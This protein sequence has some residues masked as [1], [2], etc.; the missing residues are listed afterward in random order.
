[1]QLKVQNRSSFAFKQ[2]ESILENDKVDKDTAS[3]LAGVPTNIITNG[4]GQYLAFLL[5]K[6]PQRKPLEKDDD[7]KKRLAK[8]KHVIAFNILKKWLVN[9][10][11]VLKET[12]DNNMQFFEKFTA[13]KDQKVYL[14]AQREAVEI[15]NWVQRYAKAFETEV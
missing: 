13:I 10:I 11:V 1:M 9:E 4:I 12:Q 14:R 7:Y 15:M 2:I 8:D 6:K 5:S 3:F